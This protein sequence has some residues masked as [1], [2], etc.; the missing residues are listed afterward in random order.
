MP[1]LE[2]ILERGRSATAAA[3]V[4]RCGG[5][6]AGQLTI[7]VLKLAVAEGYRPRGRCGGRGRTPGGRDWIGQV[8]RFASGCV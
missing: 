2:F 5:D 8:N 7:V 3:K 1:Y 6:D 4:A